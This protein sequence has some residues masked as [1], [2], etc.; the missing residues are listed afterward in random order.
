M[1]FKYNRVS[2]LDQSTDRQDIETPVSIDKVFEDKC[3]GSST[4]RPEFQSLISHAR[5]GDA[6]YCHSM[7]RWARSTIDLLTT[8][9]ELNERGVTIVFQKESMTFTG[10]DSP[11]NKLMLGVMGAVAQFEREIIRER[12]REGIAKAKAKG[13]VYKGRTASMRLRSDISKLLDEK[14]PMR[15]IA[16]E[17]GC[18]LSTVQRIKK[19]LSQ[20]VS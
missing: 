15:S 13:S 9:T 16:K 4:D 11:T 3:S 2:S 18:S 19:E 1:N 10:N 12:Q 8:V 7:D 14:M 17:V 5:E 6:I 20:A